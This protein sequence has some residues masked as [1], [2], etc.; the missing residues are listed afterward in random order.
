MPPG[1]FGFVRSGACLPVRRFF[2]SPLLDAMWMSSC[3]TENSNRPDE[4][5]EIRERM[6]LSTAGPGGPRQEA[7][8]R[9]DAGLHASA[10]AQPVLFA[11]HL[12]AYYEMMDRDQARLA[13]CLERVKCPTVGIR[14]AFWN[15]LSGGPAVS[16]AS[17]GISQGNP[18]IAWMP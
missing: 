15:E 4:I 8:G 11:H 12:L 13:D 9:G 16:G 2:R 6:N 10:T 3:S 7:F 17:S 14:S 18:K 5:G 1:R